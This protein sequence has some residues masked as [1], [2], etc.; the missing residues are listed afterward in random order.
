M[1]KE[2][3]IE[4]L[5]RRGTNVKDLSDVKYRIYDEDFSFYASSDEELIEYAEEQKK[6]LEDED[7]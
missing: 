6:E 4:I 5:K 3:A 2:E 1:N 7:E